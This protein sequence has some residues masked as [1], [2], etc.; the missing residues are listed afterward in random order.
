LFSRKPKKPIFEVFGKNHSPH[1]NGYSPH[2]AS[3]EWVGQRWSR[4]LTILTKLILLLTIDA[5]NSIIYMRHN[6]KINKSKHPRKVKFSFL[7]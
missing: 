2:V 4:Q 6:E 3:G 7:V 1:L 5:W